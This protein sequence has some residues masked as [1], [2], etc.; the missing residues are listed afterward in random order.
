MRIDGEAPGRRALSGDTSPL[1]AR[2]PNLNA[3]AERW[4][5]SVKAECLS[6]II[7]FGERLLRRA[8]NDYLA[9][10]HTERNHQGKNNMLL[11]RQI[12]ETRRDEPVRC[13]DRL[14]G[15]LRY[16]HRAAA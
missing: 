2:S 8:M 15:L 13:R 10:Y 9:H 12:T 5:R 16:Y 4:V 3:H 1:P 14:G 7:P 11:F 6:K